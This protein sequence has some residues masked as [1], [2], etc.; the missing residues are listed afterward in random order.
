[1]MITNSVNP[2]DVARAREL[3][4]TTFIITKPINEATIQSVLN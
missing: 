4:I 2:K 1:M 3:G